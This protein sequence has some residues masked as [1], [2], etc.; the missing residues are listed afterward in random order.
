MDPLA[1]LAIG[2]AAGLAKSELVDRPK[3]KKQREL[4]AATQRY[5]P[6]TG[7]QAQPIKEADP[8]GS[9]LGLGAAGYQA[10]IELENQ[11]TNQKIADAMIA[12]NMANSAAS[13]SP[14]YTPMPTM[15]PQYTLGYGAN[16]PI[17]RT[18][19]SPDELSSLY[20]I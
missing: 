7:L 16:S 13:A 20:G 11:A 19:K 15:A 3:E 4:A 14:G 2:A 12:N 5:S 8:F 6:W 1:L 10:G 17:W 18:V 9:A